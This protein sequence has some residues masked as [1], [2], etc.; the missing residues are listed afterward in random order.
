M[1]QLQD[2]LDEITANTRALV[3]ADRLEVNERAV[4]DLFASGIEDRILPPGAKAPDFALQD[5]S[6]RMVRSSDLLALG[7]L[8]VK[9]FRGR[10]CPY[11]VTELESWRDLYATVRKRG[12]LLVAIS[13]QTVRQNDFMRIQHS[14]DFPLL[15][16]PVCQVAGRFGLSYSVSLP[17][18]RHYRSIL[19]N[20]PLINGDQSWQL[21]IPAIYVVAQNGVV[22]FAQGHADFRV[23]PEP[24][25]TLNALPS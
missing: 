4:A 11:C 5:T 25:E 20:I 8:I 14:F 3:Q 2:R 7:P 12:A 23:R 18:R 17:H 13:P 6:N 16:D 10:W 9:F 24:L 1:P 21:P 15:S 19:V 22:I